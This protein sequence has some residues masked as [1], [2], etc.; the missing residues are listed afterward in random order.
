MH[1]MTVE[2]TNISSIGVRGGQHGS[3]R[4]VWVHSLELYMVVLLLFPG[5]GLDVRVILAVLVHLAL[6]LFQNLKGSARQPFH[7]HRGRQT[8][9]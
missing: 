4:V 5:G 7:A 6:K 1:G 8:A 2:S 9:L 3:I